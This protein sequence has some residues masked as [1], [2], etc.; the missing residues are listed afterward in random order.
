[1]RHIVPTLRKTDFKRSYESL[2]EFRS[3]NKVCA[4]QS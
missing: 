4:P 2:D 1:M 3:V